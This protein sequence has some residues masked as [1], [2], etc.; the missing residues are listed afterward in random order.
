MPTEY[1]CQR[2][3]SVHFC[4]FVFSCYLVPRYSFYTTTLWTQIH[5]FFQKKNIL[6]F[7]LIVTVW[8]DLVHSFVHSIWNGSKTMSNYCCCNIQILWWLHELCTIYQ[9]DIDPIF[10]YYS[11]AHIV[12]HSI[13]LNQVCASFSIIHIFCVEYLFS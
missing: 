4:V 3:F 13:Q 6:D 10:I 2:V 9:S 7:L 8:D 5:S 1:L 11:R 12:F